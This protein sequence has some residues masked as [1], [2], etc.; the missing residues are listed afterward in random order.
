[1]ANLLNEIIDPSQTAYVPGRSVMDNIRS[2]FYTKNLCQ[3]K[4]IDDLLI[5]L[6]AKKAFDSVSHDYTRE[7][8]KAY[9]FEDKFIKYFNM[10]YNGL[11]VKV[12]VNGFF[13]ENISIERGV[14]QGDA[15]SC[16][17]FILCMDPLIRN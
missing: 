11:S 15:L 5:S 7:T 3:S 13:S 4:K 6:D 17:L 14:K 12:L 2:N 16:S 8:L 1:M 9:S 10:L